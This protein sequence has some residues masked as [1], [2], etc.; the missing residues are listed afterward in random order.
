MFILYIIVYLDP[1]RPESEN[2]WGRAVCEPLV[3][4]KIITT[5]VHW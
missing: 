5:Y 1:I 3:H 4:I 2:A